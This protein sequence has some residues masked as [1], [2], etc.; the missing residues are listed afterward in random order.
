VASGWLEPYTVG[1]QWLGVVIDIFNGMEVVVS[2]RLAMSRACV[3][4]SRVVGPP[5][6]VAVHYEWEAGQRYTI[7]A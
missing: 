6:T 3:A 4:R 7:M 2:C 1:C 5:N